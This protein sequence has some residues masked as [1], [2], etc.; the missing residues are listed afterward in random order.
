MLGFET[1]EKS[2]SVLWTV[3]VKCVRDCSI[4]HVLVCLR[5]E[6]AVKIGFTK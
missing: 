4:N 6:M 3:W 1:H 5:P 2:V